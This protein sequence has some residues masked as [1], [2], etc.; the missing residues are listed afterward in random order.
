MRRDDVVMWLSSVLAAVAVTLVLWAAGARLG[1]AMTGGVAVL[2][3]GVLGFT[4]G[5]ARGGISS[6]RTRS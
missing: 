2:C 6:T 4:G 3:V 5:S 1:A